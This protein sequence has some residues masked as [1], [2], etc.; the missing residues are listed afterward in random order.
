M[1]MHALNVWV[2]VAAG[3]AALLVGV[4]PLLTLKG[5]PSHRRAG[6]VFVVIGAVVLGTAFIADV[7]YNPPPPLIAASFAAGYQYLSSLRALG[8][9]DRGPGWIDAMLA[10]AGLAACA[11]FFVFMGPGTASWT[12]A[13]GYSTIGYV[14]FIAIYDL[15][16]HL[17]SRSWLAHMRPLDHGLKMTGA[18]FAM[19]SAGVGNVF[20]ELQPWSQVGPSML[21]FLVMIALT[22]AYVLGRRGAAAIAP[23]RTASSAPS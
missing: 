19:M 5:G 21:G 23:T 2:H 14:A 11:A 16:R 17:W 12:P 3:A 20:R 1:E 8:L 15:T 7:L 6:R 10:I 13:I 22:I 9:R 18:Y 4:V